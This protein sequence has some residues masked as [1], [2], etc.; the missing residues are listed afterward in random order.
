MFLP[1]PVL[2]PI[3]HIPICCPCPV[4]LTYSAGR[5]ISCTVAICIIP[6]YFHC[7]N[8]DLPKRI[9]NPFRFF[10]FLI[11]DNHLEIFD[12]YAY[13]YKTELTVYCILYIS[14]FVVQ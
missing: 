8:I 5:H 1:V 2:P 3:L 12:I 6:V 7:I 4:N 11:T 9:F 14:R 10:S 13:L